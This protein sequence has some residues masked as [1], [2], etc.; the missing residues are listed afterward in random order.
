MTV[1][2]DLSVDPAAAYLAAGQPGVDTPEQSHERV[3]VVVAAGLLTTFALMAAALRAEPAPATEGAARELLEKVWR[4]AAPTW[5]QIAVPALRYAIELGRTNNLSNA[6]LEAVAAAYAEAMGE[7][8]HQTSA[9]ALLSGFQAQLNSGWDRRLAWHRAASGYG[10]DERGM[11]QYITP[12]LVRPTSYTTVEIPEATTQLLARLLHHRATSLASNESYHVSQLGKVL[13]WQYEASTGALPSDAMKR[14]VTADD[15]LV[16]P[17]CGPLHNVAVP[18]DA[19]FEVGEYRLVCPGVHPNCRCDVVLSY[20]LLEVSKADRPWN[21]TRVKRDRE[22]QFSRTEERVRVVDPEIARLVREAEERYGVEPTMAP[23]TGMVR[24]STMARSTGMTRSKGMVAAAAPPEQTVSMKRSMKRAMV[25]DTPFGAM[26]RAKSP[27]RRI[28]EIYWMPAEDGTGRMAK[29]TRDVE[30]EFDVPFQEFEDTVVLNGA[31]YYEAVINHMN[32]GKTHLDEWGTP[33][34]HPLLDLRVGSVVDL[35][36]TGTGKV[37][38]DG[39]WIAPALVGTPEPAGEMGHDWIPQMLEWNAWKNQQHSDLG[40][41][42]YDRVGIG[43]DS[44]ADS[45]MYER[46]RAPGFSRRNGP[47]NDVVLD[48]LT[49]DDLDRVAILVRKNQKYVVPGW[50]NAEE[51][52]KRHIIWDGLEENE[53][54]WRAAVEEVLQ[55]RLSAIQSESF[56]AAELLNATAREINPDLFVFHGHFGPHLGVLEGQY[57]VTSIKY[58]RMDGNQMDMQN[59]EMA[60]RDLNTNDLFHQVRVF[61]LEP[62]SPAWVP[63]TEG[64]YESGRPSEG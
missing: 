29:K 32:S 21:E 24:S 43:V 51:T 35:D 61:H 17:V 39:G 19:M 30:E 7:Y 42:A 6:D 60:E 20:A 9:D 58:H 36:Q 18:L 27:V 57:K 55:D 31:A 4:K 3:S 1:G 44:W 14:W 62:L 11:R 22:G 53:G 54:I 16:C 13:M 5:L 33:A 59:E 8:A 37:H 12:L 56:T 15:E 49:A 41:S 40:E 23:T 46:K 64:E 45:L 34:N 48:Y 50:S 10:L 47:E 2:P 52:V 38:V 63:Q 25:P 28:T 26:V